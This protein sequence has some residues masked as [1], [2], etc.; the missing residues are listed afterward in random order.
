MESITRDTIACRMSGLKRRSG[1][2][3]DA[4]P[5]KSPELRM[6]LWAELIR[7]EKV[8]DG[9]QCGDKK[10]KEPDRCHAERLAM[11]S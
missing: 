10:N 5:P 2:R 11:M 7:S 4:T 3:S 8:K 9:N 6:T 1:V